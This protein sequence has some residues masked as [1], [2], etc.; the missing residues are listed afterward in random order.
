MQFRRCGVLRWGV[1]VNDM[2]VGVDDMAAGANDMA[3]AVNDHNEVPFSA[4]IGGLFE[5]F[6]GNFP[7]F[8]PFFGQNDHLFF[9]KILVYCG[10]FSKNCDYLLVCVGLF[11]ESE[12]KNLIFRWKH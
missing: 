10:L 7:P 3:A 1:A 6:S 12:V 5:R 4:S 9:E 11:L 8:S 2:A